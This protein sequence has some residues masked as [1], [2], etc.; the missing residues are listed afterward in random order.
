M[1][2]HGKIQAIN[3][4]REFWERRKN[5]EC[6]KAKLRIKHK[7]LRGGREG[8]FS[9]NNNK[10]TEFDLYR[11]MKEAQNSVLVRTTNLQEETKLKGF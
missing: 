7:V 8:Y 2:F 11:P 6:D 3:M 9:K 10:Q 4:L 5:P 1:T